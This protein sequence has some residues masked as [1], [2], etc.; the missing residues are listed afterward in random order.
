[1]T[2]ELIKRADVKE[3]NKWN[4]SSLYLTE[5]DFENDLKSFLDL[6]SIKRWEQIIKYQGALGKD[7][8]NIKELFDIC[9]LIERKLSKI[10]TYCHLKHD[11][12]LADP[13]WQANFQKAQ[14]LYQDLFQHLSWIEPE[15]L[16]LDQGYFDQV[17]KD[18]KL[19]DYEFYFKTLSHKKEH[20]LTKDK[21]ELLSLAG[22]AL[23]TP[24]KAFSLLNN[25]DLN[26]GEVL[27]QD[28]N[29]HP[30][31]HGSYGYFM[32]GHDRVLRQNAFLQLHK[33]F[34][35]YGNTISEL[36]VGHVQSHILN[37]KARGYKDSLMSSLYPK[38]IPSKTYHNLIKTVRDN[39]HVL[40]QYVATRKEFFKLESFHL[41]DLQFPLTKEVQEKI[42][43]ETAVDWVIES[44]APLGEEYQAILA[45]GL[46]ED[47]WVDRYENKNKR[48]G[49][50]SSGCYDS[51][52]F[53]L[54]N[55]EGSLNDV[56]TLAHEAG[57]S[58]HSYLSHKHQA[59]HNSQY[60][61]FVAE[62]ASTFNESLL[63]HYLNQK[64]TSPEDKLTL[65]HQRLEGLRGTLFRQT[66]F[67]EFELYIHESTEK[68]IP[69]TSTAISE[70]YK[71]LNQ[72]YY[73]AALTLD[74]EAE[75]EW[76]RVPHFY[77]NFYVY[78]YATGISAALTLAEGVLDNKPKAQEN[79][80][81][82]LSTGG[83]A[84]P[85]DLLKIAGVDM[86]SPEPIKKALE[87]FKK[88]VDNL[89]EMNS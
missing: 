53:I 36:L 54:M 83:H 47:R 8:Q 61:I 32:H 52:P 86:E 22:M 28:G 12:D 29:K 18:S 15:L 46:K 1:M 19:K 7:A 6:P 79:Y 38:N 45:K 39:I 11:E 34:S 27:D 30:L 69:L 72:D 68:G 66:Q 58:M 42:P 41:Y 67:A 26:F 2:K 75:I 82:F 85:I 14:I 13:N 56:F 89:R 25:V 59:Y 81:K 43:Y 87:V 57:H 63:M 48:S 62:V 50:Y 35:K 24:Q 40:H 31:S 64:L 33:E 9:F 73:G 70:Y 23:A 84:Y 10:F 60:P 16:A 51:A 3:E 49:A 55:Y 78:Q 17:V 4:L 21:E 80:L 76:A 5:K 37:V 65:L 74:P 71:K 77:S 88:L 20:T 44:V